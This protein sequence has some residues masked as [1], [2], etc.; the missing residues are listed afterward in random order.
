MFSLSALACV[1]ASFQTV[2][3]GTASTYAILGASSVTSTGPTGLDGDV[4]VY[5]GTTVT[6]FPPDIVTGLVHLGNGPAAVAGPYPEAHT[7]TS[8]D[9]YTGAHS[10]NLGNHHD[11]R[12]YLL[13]LPALKRQSRHQRSEHHPQ[14]RPQ[15]PKT[16]P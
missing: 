5:P 10:H 11:H 3:L 1:L 4:G 9:T 8:A 12:F 15:G 16:Q 2:P 7:H 14:S 6:G 13:L